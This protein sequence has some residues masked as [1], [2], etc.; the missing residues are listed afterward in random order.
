MANSFARGVAEMRLGPPPGSIA[1]APLGNAE[2]HEHAS[3]LTSSGVQHPSTGH[4]SPAPVIR[5]DQV[6][7]RGVTSA[8][9]TTPKTAMVAEGARHRPTAPS[10]EC[11]DAG[12]LA[13]L[14][15]PASR[16]DGGCPPGAYRC[17]SPRPV[18]LRSEPNEGSKVPARRSAQPGAVYNIAGSIP[19]ERGKWYLALP[20]GTGFYPLQSK[21]GSP[22][23]EKEINKLAGGTTPVPPARVDWKT[24]AVKRPGDPS[25]KF[26]WQWAGNGG[27]E[28]YAGAVSLSVE[29]Q[30]LARQPN[31]GVDIAGRP[32][33]VDFDKGI[34]FGKFDSKQRQRK[35]R[36]VPANQ[37]V[38]Q[39]PGAGAVAKRAGGEAGRGE[40]MARDMPGPPPPP[41]VLL[42]TR[43]SNGT[44]LVIEQIDIALAT[45]A[46]VVNA[47]N[48]SSFTRHDAGVS[49]ALREACAP[50]QTAAVHAPRYQYDLAGQAVLTPHPLKEGGVR[51]QQ[52]YGRL[53]SQGVEWIVHALGPAWQDY[54]P[55]SPDFFPAVGQ[56]INRTVFGALVV[57]EQLR[58]TGVT[59][60]AISGGIFCHQ[61]FD[62]ASRALN[63]KEQLTARRQL[64][65]ATID[66]AAAFPTPAIR[67]IVVVTP[68]PVGRRT[69]KAAGEAGMLLEAAA[70]VTPRLM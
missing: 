26:K 33:V 5:A 51:F 42:A 4:A 27:W 66:W 59:L 32:Y 39:V 24:N 37:S 56:Q 38:A 14:S 10:L 19:G 60:P 28:D 53:R 69:E 20:G 43:L 49:G 34:Q 9:S 48:A 58:A 62:A 47:A 61:A 16:P 35:V 17:V 52:A 12:N 15:H 67:R 3:L 2:K 29:Q 18:A 6:R 21:A 64:L 22:L 23:F 30:F 36:R 70:Q 11:L 7:D 40:R 31:A 50:D 55:R 44:E 54:N 1:A 46:V 68:P 13:L 63:A 57:A 65:Q 25:R 8:T 41:V 45:T